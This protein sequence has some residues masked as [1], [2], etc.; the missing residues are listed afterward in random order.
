M[1][2]DQSPSTPAGID[3]ASS[4]AL[5][6]IDRFSFL[7]FKGRLPEQDDDKEEVER[8]FW[9]SFLSLFLFLLHE[10]DEGGVA[11]IVFAFLRLHLRRRL[12]L[13]SF[14]PTRT[15]GVVEPRKED[16]CDMT[17]KQDQL[18]YLFLVRRAHK[19]FPLS[20]SLLLFF[21]FFSMKKAAR[22]CLD[23][24]R[25]RA[26][27]LSQISLRIGLLLSPGSERR[28]RISLDRFEVLR[29]RKR[30]EEKQQTLF[31]HFYNKNLNNNLSR[32][33]SARGRY[34]TIIISS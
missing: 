13:A 5:G 20:L 6:I 23:C 27:A 2:C 8:S 28:K 7:P 3:C 19:F 11:I 24:Y 25:I 21:F 10:N 16:E 26:D 34:I 15:V 9:L 18:D 29:R 22:G 17:D 12:F 32:A 4:I 31:L 14:V 30:R 1:T 33:A